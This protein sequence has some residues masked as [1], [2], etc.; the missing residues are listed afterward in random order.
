MSIDLTEMYAYPGTA[1]AD[2]ADIDEVRLAE[3]DVVDLLPA[4]VDGFG[5]EFPLNPTCENYGESGCVNAATPP[6]DGVSGEAL[7]RID[8]R[9]AELAERFGLDP[10][11]PGESGRQEGQGAE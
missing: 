6:P 8:P 1:A 2:A 11:A 3:D 9:F 5:L 4:L 7:P 10:D